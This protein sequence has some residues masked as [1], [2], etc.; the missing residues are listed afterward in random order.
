MLLEATGAAGAV[1]RALVTVKNL[2]AGRL[3]RPARGHSLPG[4][5]FVPPPRS[6]SPSSFPV[7]A[8]PP[9]PDTADATQNGGPRFSFHEEKA[10]EDKAVDR[11]KTFGGAYDRKLEGRGERRGFENGAEMVGDLPDDP[12]LEAFFPQGCGRLHEALF[13]RVG[14]RPG[15]VLPFNE[16]VSCRRSHMACFSVRFDRFCWARD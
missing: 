12:L 15:E 6:P 5:V 14:E 13:F 9:V 2:G 8:N 10:K 1:G 7:A 3:P 11:G 16:R 4:G